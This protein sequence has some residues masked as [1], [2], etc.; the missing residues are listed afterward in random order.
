M[1]APVVGDDDHA[2]HHLPQPFD[3]R[4]SLEGVGVRSMRVNGEERGVRA[5][6]G[7]QRVRVYVWQPARTRT[8]PAL[9]RPSNEKGQVMTPTVRMP[10]GG[11]RG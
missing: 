1:A 8:W 6:R 3:A 5:V 4:Q 2:V 10:A 7:L 11:K 9:R